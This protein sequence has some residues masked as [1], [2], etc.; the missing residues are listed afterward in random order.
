M[1]CG[2]FLLY[3]VD[4]PPRKELKDMTREE[5]VRFVNDIRNN[6]IPFDVALTQYHDFIWK[7]INE[8][9][10]AGLEND[11]LYSILSCELHL[12]IQN[13]D[14][15]KGVRFMSYLGTCFHN[16]LS[17]EI[18]YS[19]RKKNGA[20][21]YS[22]AGRL[23]RPYPCQY[24]GVGTTYRDILLTGDYANKQIKAN[25]LVDTFNELLAQ[26]DKET[27]SLVL[28]I[29]VNEKTFAEIGQELGITGAGVR[30]R[31]TKYIKQLQK[32]LIRKG[33]T[34]TYLA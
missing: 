3:N 19:K 23:D 7:I 18:A 24:D 26:A 10:I 17:L 31:Y 8:Y 2:C 22:R 14:A 11:D 6:V 20:E 12:A 33:I 30:F 34:S 32:Q 16:K 21:E 27:I 15:D 29:L 28:D 4:V 13:Y 25:Y 5:E 1:T 9:N